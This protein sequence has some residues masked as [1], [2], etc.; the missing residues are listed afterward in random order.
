MNILILKRN[1][2]VWFD[3]AHGSEILECIEHGQRRYF[4]REFSG[5]RWNSIDPPSRFRRMARRGSAV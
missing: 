5:R 1:E 2:R 3:E 4:E